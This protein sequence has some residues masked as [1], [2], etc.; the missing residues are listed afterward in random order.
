V[1]VKVLEIDGAQASALRDGG[2]APFEVRV[3]LDL[4]GATQWHTITVRPRV[5]RGLDASLVVASD[6]LQE[7]LRFEQNALHRICKLVGRD[8]RGGAVRLPQEVAA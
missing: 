5:L 1:N 3:L 2:P 8:V 7:A 4:D 6:A